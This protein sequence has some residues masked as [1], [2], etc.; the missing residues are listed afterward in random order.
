MKSKERHILN[1]ILA[2]IILVGFV[3]LLFLLYGGEYLARQIMPPLPANSLV[4]DCFSQH[5]VLCKNIDYTTSYA[6]QEILGQWSTTMSQMDNLKGEI[7]YH[8]KKCNESWLGLHYASFHKR[9]EP[10]CAIVDAWS[11]NDSNVSLLG[12]FV[13]R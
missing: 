7:I 4:S 6:P 1:K 8:S 12:R 11:E 13:P 2:L 3:D 10:A 5:K 9:R